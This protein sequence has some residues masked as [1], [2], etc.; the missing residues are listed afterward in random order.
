MAEGAREAM[1][2]SEV[3]SYQKWV[4]SQGIPVIKGLAVEDLNKVPLE[5]WERM[6]GRGSFIVLEGGGGTNDAY[7]CEIAPGAS[8]KPEHHMYEELIYILQGRGATTT[9]V[10]G[11]E[12]QTFEWQAGSLFTPPLN[13][14]HQHFNGGDE[15]VR[16]VAVTSAPTFIDL[17]H[18]MDFI[19]N[20]DFVFRDRY[21]A[22]SDFFTRNKWHPRRLW[23]INFIPDVPNLP[24]REWKERGAGGTNVT[25]EMADNT[26]AAHVSEFPVGT[27]KKC[28][29]HGP[30]AQIVLLSGKGYS[31]MWK[32]GQPWNKI[33]WHTGSFFVPPDQW[34][35]QHFNTGKEPAR[36]MAL[37][38]GS[39]K[40]PVGG[41]FG[42]SKTS[43]ADVSLKDGGYQVEYEDED[44]E[45]RRLFEQ[46]CAKEGV[47][48]KMP[49]FK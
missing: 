34:F 4:E 20:N 39:Q 12:K 11:G 16:F 8:L 45:V 42:G 32:E 17:F 2:F 15:P 40:Y 6:G 33:D 13:V 5:P 22:S 31:I 49:R 27:Y 41:I 10:E 9:W 28:H 47:E 30:G 46:E 23:E 19:F 29:K 26:M 43:L 14:W 18:N 38:W 24:L 35:H 36:Y 7:V 25:F 3:T 21:D 1:A 37:R 44:P 48:V